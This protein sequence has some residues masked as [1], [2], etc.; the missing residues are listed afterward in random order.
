MRNSRCLPLRVFEVAAI[1][2]LALALA[3]R[4]A[5]AGAA[6]AG[7]T[8]GADAA[9][10]KARNEQMARGFQALCD[11][12]KSGGVSLRELEACLPKMMQGASDRDEGGDGASTMPPGATVMQLLD[13]DGDGAVTLREY[14]AVLDDMAADARSDSKVVTLQTRDGRVRKISRRELA[15]LL[16]ES[17]ATRAKMMGGGREQDEEPQE[18]KRHTLQELAEQNPDMAK[19]VAV[20]KWAADSL[21][22]QGHAIG[23]LVQLKSLPTGGSNFRD[24][25]G[26][27]S[28]VDMI[29][30]GGTTHSDFW[31]EFSA[32]DPAKL[33]TKGRLYYEV[34]IERNPAIYRRPYLAIK[35]AWQ[36]TPEGKRQGELGVPKPRL[37]RRPAAHGEINGDEQEHDDSR[38]SWSAI[39]PVIGLVM[40]C[41]WSVR[42]FV[43][44]YIEVRR[45]K[46]RLALE[47]KRE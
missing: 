33:A 24:K 21:R 13:V 39:F 18:P 36:L 28:E 9:A 44:E 15:K 25:A 42:S 32:Q 19:F 12:D 17:E 27:A 11:A 10:G 4:A 7:T 41:I 22:A 35:G 5:T 16:Q 20:V 37:A 6:A 23:E 31:I 2:A 14:M 34:Y 29:D 3:S 43:G 46:R 47:K 8:V 30:W 45:I 40:L 26:A 1:L 38:F